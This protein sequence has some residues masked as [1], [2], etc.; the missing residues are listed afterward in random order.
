[1]IVIDNNGQSQTI[2]PGKNVAITDGSGNGVIVGKNGGKADVS[3]PQLS[4][5][6]K[7]EY[8]LN[9][10]FAKASNTNYGLD[11]KKLDQLKGNYEKLNDTYYVSW[12]AVS[13][14][15]D[16][17]IA[18]YNGKDNIADK[19]KFELDG[20]PATATANGNSFTINIGAATQTQLSL[21]AKATNGDKEQI[22]GKL[23]VIGYDAK[24]VNLKIVK[25]NNAKFSLDAP[26]V[27]TQLDKNLFTSCGE[28]ECGGCY[29]GTSSNRPRRSI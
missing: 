20:A 2:P 29:S 26:T 12:K 19:I 9:L 15:P 11:E 6:L 7:R 18:T 28:L 14:L 21:V 5:I 25:V 4:S 24:P 8:N 10:T 23:N 27:K 16:A 13:S 1:M 3:G 22:L 17:V